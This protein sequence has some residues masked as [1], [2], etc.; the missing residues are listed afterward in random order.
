MPARFYHKRRRHQSKRT[1][2]RGRRRR[3]VTKVINRGK[4]AI[5]RGLRPAVHY[6]KR[7]QIE[8]L[9]PSGSVPSWLGL[10]DDSMAYQGTFG[11]DFT[12]NIPSGTEFVNLFRQYKILGVKMTLLFDPLKMTE[13]TTRSMILRYRWNRAGETIPS[14]TAIADWLQEQS[15]RTMMIPKYRKQSFYCRPRVSSSLYASVTT[16]GYGVIRPPWLSLHDS[17]S[18][19]VDHYCWDFRFENA[20][21]T[22]LSTAA[23]PVVAIETQIYFKCKQVK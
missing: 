17:G 22:T 7:S 21:G 14:S 3:N 16:S 6:F 1:Q 15:T 4:L 23:L 20:D 8:Y 11:V 10:S 19:G 2:V 13:S 18:L 12:N 9:G 5:P